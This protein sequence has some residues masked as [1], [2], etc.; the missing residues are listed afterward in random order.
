MWMNDVIIIT[1]DKE[2]HRLNRRDG[3]ML[4]SPQDCLITEAWV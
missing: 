1:Y 3:F 4:Y 2:N